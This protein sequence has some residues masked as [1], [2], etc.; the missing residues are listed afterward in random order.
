MQPSLKLCH[1]GFA[2]FFLFCREES[3]KKKKKMKKSFWYLCV[4]FCV[5]F[6][7]MCRFV[8]VYIQIYVCFLCV[9]CGCLVL[10]GIV[11]LDLWMVCL[12]VVGMCI[13]CVCVYLCVCVCVFLSL[14][15]SLSTYQ[16]FSLVAVCKK[17][18][19]GLLPRVVGSKTTTLQLLLLATTTPS[20]ASIPL[21]YGLFCW[22]GFWF[23][24]SSILQFFPFSLSPILSISSISTI[25]ISP[26][27]QQTVFC[28]SLINSL[29]VCFPKKKKTFWFFF[30]SPPPP[31]PPPPHFFA[32][33]RV[34]KSSDDEDDKWVVC[35]QFVCFPPPFLLLLLLPFVSSLHV[36]HV[37]F[38]IAVFDPNLYLSFFD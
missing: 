21:S 35:C 7:W 18:F 24:F 10:G 2:T 14:S 3:W 8:C 17:H 20:A 23:L 4:W 12:C 11:F 28:P 38:P 5:Y 19:Q 31:P 32:F 37:P 29:C 26:Y 15:L 36:L 6:L 33:A 30:Y 25:L 27:H 34:L 9:F 1:I 22:F 13:S 16:N